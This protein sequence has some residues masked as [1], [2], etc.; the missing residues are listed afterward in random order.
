MQNSEQ[1]FIGHSKR[2]LSIIIM[3]RNS[4]VVIKL[5]FFPGSEVEKHEHARGMPKGLGLHGAPDNGRTF[6]TAL[7]LL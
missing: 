5:P 1:A 6:V 4:G 2:E 7:L 3:A